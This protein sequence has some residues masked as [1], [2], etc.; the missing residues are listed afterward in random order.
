MFAHSKMLVN[1]RCAFDMMGEE[2]D[3]KVVWMK[4]LLLL[5]VEA[6]SSGCLGNSTHGAVDPLKLRTFKPTMGILYRYEEL[7]NA[8][9]CRTGPN[10]IQSNEKHVR[11]SNTALGMENTQEGARLPPLHI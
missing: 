2:G 10:F 9:S 5:Q 7:T 4:L 8:V 1:Q 3:G 11:L 6:L